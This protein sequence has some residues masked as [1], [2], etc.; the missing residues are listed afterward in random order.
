MSGGKQ[1]LQ[2]TARR[3]LTLLNVGNLITNTALQPF[4]VP[5]LTCVLEGPT[6]LRGTLMSNPPFGSF[7]PLR[8][9]SFGGSLA[10]SQSQT[11]FRMAWRTLQTTKTALETCFRS[12]RIESNKIRFIVLLIRSLLSVCT[13]WGRS[14]SSVQPGAEALWGSSEQSPAARR[15]W[16]SWWPG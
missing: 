1:F 14:S 6:A 16:Y 5:C 7:S 15:R 12:F 3:R 11:V 2:T 9:G 13:W 10:P 8:Q 4:S